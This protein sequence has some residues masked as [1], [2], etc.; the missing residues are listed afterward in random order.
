M[1]PTD[2]DHALEQAHAPAAP[3]PSPVQPMGDALLA[4]MAPLAQH[5]IRKHGLVNA[6]GQLHCASCRRVIDWH[7]SLHCAPCRVD[8]RT[9]RSDRLRQER[10]RQ[11]LEQERNR[12]QEESR[13]VQRVANRSF[14]DG[15]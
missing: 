7:I 10:E 2:L 11:R 4:A 1:T 13:P 12:E 3:A 14:R 8:E 6:A 5:L 9:A 15:Y